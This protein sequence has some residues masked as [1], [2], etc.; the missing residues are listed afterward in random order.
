LEVWDRESFPQAFAAAHHGLGRVLS[1]AAE[2]EPTT[3]LAIR[4]FNFAT[5]V[6]RRGEVPL[7]WA[8]TQHRLA[9][10][11]LGLA[12]FVSPFEG[13]GYFS[14][15]VEIYRQLEEVWTVE[16]VPH[17]WYAA[18]LSRTTALGLLA[19][20]SPGRDG[21]LL[22]EEMAETC[23][24]VLRHDRSALPNEARVPVYEILAEATTQRAFRALEDAEPWFAE[25]AGARREALALVDREA[26]PAS[27][28]VAAYDL[29]SAL[30]TW[31]WAMTPGADAGPIL[32]EA[33]AVLTAAVREATATGALAAHLPR[34]K[35]AEVWWLQD[36]RNEAVGLMGQVLREDPDDHD[37]YLILRSWVQDFLH[38]FELAYRTT[39]DWVDRHPE[40][41]GARV[42]LTQNFFTTGRF[43]ACLE[44]IAATRLDPRLG[45]AD[46]AFLR[47]FE[48]STLRILGHPANEIADLVEHLSEA[49]RWLSPDLPAAWNTRSS[50]HFVKES[51]AASEHRAWL[52]KLFETLRSPDR[53]EVVEGLRRLADTT[54]S[55]RV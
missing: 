19:E 31:V 17:L 7:L 41:Y 30:L 40:E 9:K 38:D 8:S 50:S 3:R 39:S 10:P 23:R 46:H 14:R 28:A 12:S 54:G 36:R 33:D 1:H 20:T 24:E 26:Q 18:P 35:L 42:A 4:S 44:H 15:V 43:D 5:E 21:I 27:W 47:V 52:V 13:R 34:A 55:Q 2:D 48:I 22:Y 49:I 53:Q 6:R 29:G 32:E 16:E 11:L 37:G 25:A 45:P 51:E